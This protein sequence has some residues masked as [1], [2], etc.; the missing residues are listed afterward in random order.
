MLVETGLDFSALARV[1]TRPFL[2][3]KRQISPNKRILVLYLVLYK[4]LNKSPNQPSICAKDCSCYP[5][6]AIS[7]LAYAGGIFATANC[8]APK[9]IFLHLIKNKCAGYKLSN[10]FSTN[11]VIVSKKSIFVMIPLLNHK[12]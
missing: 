1:F 6:E 2:Y 12:L 10:S 4:T 8:H 3:L 7:A 9:S 11:E 5:G